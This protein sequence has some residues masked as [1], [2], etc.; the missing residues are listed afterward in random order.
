MP[1]GGSMKKTETYTKSKQLAQYFPLL[2][3]NGYRV[4]TIGFWCKQCHVIAHPGAIYGTVSRIT[5]HAADIRAS[6]LCSC[7][8]HSTYRIR[9]KDDA[10]YQYIEDDCWHTKSGK[11]SYYRKLWLYLAG[12]ALAAVLFWH[13]LKLKRSLKKIQYRLRTDVKD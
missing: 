8:C 4:E 6:L 9:L 11:L 12:K 10:S 2:F 5:P 7:G 13:S 3:N 1:A